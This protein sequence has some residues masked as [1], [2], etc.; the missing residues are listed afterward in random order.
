MTANLRIAP[1]AATSAAYT[2]NKRIQEQK[3]F[4]ILMAVSIIL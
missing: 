4:E 3:R 1:S 2:R